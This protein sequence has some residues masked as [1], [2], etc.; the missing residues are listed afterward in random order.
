MKRALE[1]DPASL[2]INTG[3]GRVLFYERRYRDAAAQYTKT[4]EMNPEFSEALFDLGRT[5]AAQGNYDG[6]AAMIERGLKAARE[7]AGAL[8]DIAWIRGRAK[9]TAQAEQAVL[10]LQALSTKRYV[11]PYF[12]AVAHSGTRDD[13]TLEFL[14][15]AWRERAFS[16]I[17]L[18]VDPRFDNLRAHARYRRLLEQL[19]FSS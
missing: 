4:L 2:A 1:L 18:N 6:A 5:L 8:A 13:V 15:Q 3:V 11:S 19:G 10:A 7:D 9:R 17:Y 12:F 14:E 16:M